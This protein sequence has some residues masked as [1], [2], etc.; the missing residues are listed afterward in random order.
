M[1]MPVEKWPRRG[2]GSGRDGGPI[3]E[4][5]DRYMAESPRPLASRRWSRSR[6]RC[7][8]RRLTEVARAPAAAGASAVGDRVPVLSQR[9]PLNEYKTEAFQLFESMLES[10]RVQ[11]TEQLSRI[12]SA[13]E[14]RA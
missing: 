10:L 6:S 5:S 3:I 4:N 2:R 12:R 13:D 11:V 8:C 9:D 7:C 1:D 14:G